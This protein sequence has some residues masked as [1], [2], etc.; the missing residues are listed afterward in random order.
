M[1]AS[2]TVFD[3]KAEEKE[4]WAPAIRVIPYGISTGRLLHL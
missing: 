1:Q 4:L 2:K 3:T